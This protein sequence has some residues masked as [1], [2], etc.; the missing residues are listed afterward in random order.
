MIHDLRS[1]TP[2]DPTGRFIYPAYG[3][4]CFGDISNSILALMGVDPGR[5]VL[6]PEILTPIRAQPFKHILFLMI[7]GLGFDNWLNRALRYPFFH[8]ITVRG[9]VSSLTAVFPSTTSASLTSFSTGLTPQE[10]GLP[11]WTIYLPEIDEYIFSLPFR[12][13][14]GERNDELVD[15][16]LDMSI[17]FQSETTVY[18]KL[19]EQG[20]PSVHFASGAYSASA[21]SAASYKGA[22]RESFY[23]LADL[24]TRLADRMNAAQTPSFFYVYWDVF[25]NLEH[26]YSPYSDEPELELEHFS[27]FGTQLLHRLDPRILKDTLLL[28]SADH[29][30][31]EVSADRVTYLS[32]YAEIVATFAL[33]PHQRPYLPV[34]GPRDAFLH[35]RPDKQAEAQRRLA[36]LLEG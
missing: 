7:D 35:V 28:V 32:D 2:G 33:R 27:L 10:H 12:R 15:A 8:E 23:M 34:G 36:C 6:R 3:G 14:N 19:A 29:G 20:I 25:D 24:V 17:L 9:D 21:Y 22:E 5:P 11:E 18:Q 26:M 4:G 13:W 16:G 31:S 30:Q 1:T